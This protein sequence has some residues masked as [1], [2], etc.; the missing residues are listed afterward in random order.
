[1]II[2]DTNRYWTSQLFNSQPRRFTKHI[3]QNA[4][5]FDLPYNDAYTELLFHAH[6]WMLNIHRC[7][8][9]T[10]QSW[11]HGHLVLNFRFYLFEL[12]ALIP[13]QILVC[14]MC[15]VVPTRSIRKTQ[16]KQND[17]NTTENQHLMIKHEL[18][19]TGSDMGRHITWH[20]VWS[21]GFWAQLISNDKR[22]EFFFYVLCS[23]GLLIFML[24]LYTAITKS[25]LFE[26]TI[27]K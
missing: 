24:R 10:N 23:V 17:S 9:N 13:S 11:T 19:Q 12:H 21:L 8:R 4:L 15:T 22:H 1:M 2:D 16:T 5:L 20:W 27:Y 26:Y 25:C 14:S 6:R 3:N 18:Q 7:A